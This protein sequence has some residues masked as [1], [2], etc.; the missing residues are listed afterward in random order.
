[1]LAEVLGVS[2]ADLLAKLS[3]KEIMEWRAMEKINGPYG[4]VRDDMLSA[5]MKMMYASAHGVKSAKISDYMMFTE[6]K[7]QTEEEMEQAIIR[8]LVGAQ[9]PEA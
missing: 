2:V 5:D 1:M 8:S 9:W 3:A 6:R 4:G 7:E